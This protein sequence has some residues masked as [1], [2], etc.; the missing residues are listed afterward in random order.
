MNLPAPT[1]WNSRACLELARLAK[2][3]HP[4]PCIVPASAATALCVAGINA[5]AKRLYRHVWVI[6]CS[7]QAERR[8]RGLLTRLREPLALRVSYGVCA[9]DKDGTRTAAD[10]G[11]WARAVHDGNTLGPAAW[12]P[13]NARRL[14]KAPRDELLCVYV[15]PAGHPYAEPC[16]RSVIRSLGLWDITVMA[17]GP[18]RWHW[19][20]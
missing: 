8:R 16:D 11:A 7:P 6:D 12:L 19:D 14:V 10:P 20:G 4:E 3:Q 5:V 15:A 2:Q 13:W 18:V 17:A 1:V 9:P